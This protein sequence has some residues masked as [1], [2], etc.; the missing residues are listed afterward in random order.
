MRR[1][2]TNEASQPSAASRVQ[3]DKQTLPFESTVINA[4]VVLTQ[5]VVIMKT[6]PARI[7]CNS[8]AVNPFDFESSRR[9]SNGR[10][11]QFNVAGVQ[12]SCFVGLICRFSQFTPAAAAAAVVTWPER[13]FKNGQYCRLPQKKL[14]FKGGTGLLHP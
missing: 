7:V 8:S 1:G 2:R 13:E 9:G 5:M 12:V 14:T 4:L 11:L 6:H 10:D 3:A